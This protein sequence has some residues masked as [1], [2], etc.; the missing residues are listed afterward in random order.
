LGFSKPRFQNFSIFQFAITTQIDEGLTYFRDKNWHEILI[1]QGQRSA[2]QDDCEEQAPTLRHY[3]S[4]K[5]H[6]A[7]IFLFRK[8]EY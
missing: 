7:K 1:G 6:S 2:M 3:A 5:Q 4:E 8:H